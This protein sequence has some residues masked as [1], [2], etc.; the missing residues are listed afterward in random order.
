M[1]FLSLVFGGIAIG[2]LLRY[3]RL[4]LWED[5]LLAGG[6]LGAVL[7]AWLTGPAVSES[8]ALAFVFPMAACQIAAGFFLHRRYRKWETSGPRSEASA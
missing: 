3:R 7:T 8:F 2:F 5:V 6:A 1:V 4:G